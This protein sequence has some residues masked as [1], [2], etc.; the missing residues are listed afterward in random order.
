MRRVGVIALTSVEEGFGLVAV[1]AAALGVPFVGAHVGGLAE[2]CGLLAQP[3]FPPG[4]SP[5]LARAISR[6]FAH[7]PPAVP[8]ESLAEFDPAAVA[9]R[10]L[11]LGRP[12]PRVREV[13]G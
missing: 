1:E 3:T 12:A 5:A 13:R 11:E 2:V 6:L 8:A 9:A 7:R 10:Y 4:D